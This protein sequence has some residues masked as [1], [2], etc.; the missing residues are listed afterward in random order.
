MSDTYGQRNM[1]LFFPTNYS[2]PI[3][4]RLRHCL[5]LSVKA[6]TWRWISNVNCYVVNIVFIVE[7]GVVFISLTIEA[8][9]RDVN[10]N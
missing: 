8:T 6:N 5:L 7:I 1:R 9:G 2:L 10:I 4:I 3:L